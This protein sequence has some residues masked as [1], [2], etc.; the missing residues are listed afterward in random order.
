MTRVA[1]VFTADLQIYRQGAWFKASRGIMLHH[2]A[3]G[4]VYPPDTV[5]I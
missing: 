1:A 5:I 3:S 2:L 4:D